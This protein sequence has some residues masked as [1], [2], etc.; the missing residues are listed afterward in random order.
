MNTKIE[1][2]FKQNKKS[3]IKYKIKTHLSRS[4]LMASSSLIFEGVVAHHVCCSNLFW[5]NIRQGEILDLLEGCS[6]LE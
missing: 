3:N 1:N 5:S 4:S 2:S 6:K